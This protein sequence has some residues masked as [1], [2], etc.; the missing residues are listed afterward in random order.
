[1]SANWFVVNMVIV[2]LNET[3]ATTSAV[4]VL[5]AMSSTKPT[6]SNGTLFAGVTVVPVRTQNRSRH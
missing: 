2:L 4:A 1:M 3:T 5:L 6:V